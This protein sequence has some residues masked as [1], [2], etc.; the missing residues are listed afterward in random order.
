MYSFS[1]CVVWY[2]WSSAANKFRNLAVLMVLTHTWRFF[3]HSYKTLILNRTRNG[4]AHVA[5][6]TELLMLLIILPRII[7]YVVR[8][9]LGL[10]LFHEILK[11][12]APVN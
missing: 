8:I 7:Q 6:M 5:L 4:A 1:E 12:G 9:P 3:F 2:R 10:L 11:R